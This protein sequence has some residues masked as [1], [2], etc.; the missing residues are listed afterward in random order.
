MKWV[1]FRDKMW[2]GKLG[3]FV[4]M[5]ADRDVG[6]SAHVVFDH[7]L[8]SFTLD[9][10]VRATFLPVVCKSVQLP[11]SVLRYS[12]LPTLQP[13]QT[14]RMLH[15]PELRELRQLRFVWRAYISLF[16]RLQ[17]LRSS[18]QQRLAHIFQGRL[19]SKLVD[20]V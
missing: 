5:D 1:G 3:E 17:E 18:L 4:A 7:G 14:I 13:F 11:Q 6:K 16:D 2:R 20:L 9:L 19:P 8:D 12:V 15:T 10:P